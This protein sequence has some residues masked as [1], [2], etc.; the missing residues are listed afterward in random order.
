VY[1]RWTCSINERVVADSIRNTL[2]HP[3]LDFEP[4]GGLYYLESGAKIALL[5]LLGSTM[6]PLWPSALDCPPPRLR[7]PRLGD[8]DQLAA[9]PDLL[10]GVDRPPSSIR[11]PHALDPGLPAAAGLDG[12]GHHRCELGEHKPCQHLGMEAIDDQHRLGDAAR[13]ASEQFERPPLFCAK[14]TLPLRP[15]RRGQAVPSYRRR[16]AISFCGSFTSNNLTASDAR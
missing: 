12:L 15:F 16:T 3:I 10:S 7:D 8:R 5:L 6:R 14:V 4:I 2:G 1:L 9:G 13:A 11:D